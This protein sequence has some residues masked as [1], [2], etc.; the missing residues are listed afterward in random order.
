[1]APV[2][3][4]SKPSEPTSTFNVG[5][6]VVDL[7]S[8]DNSPSIVIEILRYDGASHRYRLDSDNDNAP[9]QYHRE[10]D[11]MFYSDILELEAHYRKCYGEQYGSF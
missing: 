2:L 1:M 10:Y 6:Q 9:W 4:P 7:L 3:G 11:L 8:E 5:D